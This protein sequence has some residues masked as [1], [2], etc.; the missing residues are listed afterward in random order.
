MPTGRDTYTQL[1]HDYL[2]DID[3]YSLMRVALQALAVL[4]VTREPKSGSRTRLLAAQ[5]AQMA[6]FTTTHTHFAIA[7]THLLVR[8]EKTHHF[9]PLGLTCTRS[10]WRRSAC[11]M[12]AG[13]AAAAMPLA[14]APVMPGGGSHRHVILCGSV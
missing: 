6:C 5:R 12:L 4:Q 7:A 1:E 3:E 8:F 10:E 9:C 11:S 2:H 14:L 13:M